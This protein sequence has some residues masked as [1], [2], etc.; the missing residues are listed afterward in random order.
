MREH[1]SKSKSKAKSNEAEFRR[2]NVQ[3]NFGAGRQVVA[4]LQIKLIP[5]AAGN[6]KKPQVCSIS[7]IF[8][9]LEILQR[10]IQKSEQAERKTQT[11]DQRRAAALNSTNA[12]HCNQPHKK[13]PAVRSI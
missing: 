13:Q 8:R 2:R 3:R 4:I 1:K 10:Q 6:K 5:S 9:T 12:A 11:S 7:D